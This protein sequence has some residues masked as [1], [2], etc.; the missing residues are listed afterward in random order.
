MYVLQAHWQP[1]RKPAGTG[2]VLFWAETY[3]PAGVKAGGE[4]R[5]PR[6]HPFRA[7]AADLRTLLGRAEARTETFTL[8]LPSDTKGPLPSLRHEV[9]QGSSRKRK[10]KLRAWNVPGLRYLQSSGS[11]LAIPRAVR[12]ATVLSYRWATVR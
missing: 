1:S 7:D 9:S 10:P 5:W 8:R 3:P 12:T 2:A 4:K 6:D 11:N